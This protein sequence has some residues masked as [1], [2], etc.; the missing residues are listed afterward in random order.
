MIQRPT[1]PAAIRGSSKN[2]NLQADTNTVDD[3]TERNQ[4]LAAML[5]HLNEVNYQLTKGLYGFDSTRGEG[6]KQ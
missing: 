6:E 1:T 2:Q 4:L 5:I 3:E